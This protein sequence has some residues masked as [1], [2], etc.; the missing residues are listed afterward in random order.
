MWLKWETLLPHQK[1]IL[2]LIKYSK[3]FLQFGDQHTT[4]YW[5]PNP[6]LPCPLYQEVCYVVEEVVE[7]IRC[8]DT[9]KKKHIQ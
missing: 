5:S 3:R 2:R 4:I 7:Y 1:P 9:P 6:T 8:N